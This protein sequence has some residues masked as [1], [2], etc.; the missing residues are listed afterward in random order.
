MRQGSVD[1]AA[2][3]YRGA[4]CMW[5]ES[6]PPRAAE[7]EEELKKLVAEHPE[8]GRYVEEVDWKVE[9]EYARWLSQQ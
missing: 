7:A 4:V 9:E 1:G 8:C 5:E 3:S 6:S 2:A